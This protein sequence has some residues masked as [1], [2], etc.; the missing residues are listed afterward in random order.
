M[1]CSFILFYFDFTSCVRYQVIYI[2]MVIAYEYLAGG[3]DVNE[4]LGLCCVC[5]CVLLCV[6]VRACCACYMCV[7]HVQ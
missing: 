3:V 2:F 1:A 4:V 7:F 5:M 6:H